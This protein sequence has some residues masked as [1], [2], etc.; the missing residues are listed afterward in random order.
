MYNTY[1]HLSYDLCGGAPLVSSS[2]R[3]LRCVSPGRANTATGCQA[4]HP[5]PGLPGQTPCP[6]EAGSRRKGCRVLLIAF[7]SLDMNE[8]RTCDNSDLPRYLLPTLV[9]LT[10]S[11]RTR[12]RRNPAVIVGSVASQAFITFRIAQSCSLRQDRVAASAR[13]FEG[14]E[15][16]SRRGVSYSD[17]HATGAKCHWQSILGTTAN[18]TAVISEK[19]NTAMLGGVE[20]AVSR[21][22][23]E[24]FTDNVHEA[25]GI[26]LQTRSLCENEPPSSEV[27]W[28]QA[29]F[30]LNIEKWTTYGKMD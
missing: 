19:K 11:S 26:F 14:G 21:T 18:N 30:P 4:L 28:Q 3:P 10:C 25:L 6:N 9:R 16:P 24:P 22:R 15:I 29:T 7:L 20:K 12:S 2:H 5:V 27:L 13:W 1:L 8:D 23:P 17:H